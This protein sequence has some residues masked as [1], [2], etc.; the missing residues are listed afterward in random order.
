MFGELLFSF[1]SLKLGISYKAK[2]QQIFSDLLLSLA[3][4]GRRLF[5]FVSS[6][7]VGPIN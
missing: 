4:G 5:S 6:G 2:K 3:A 1:D 7:Q